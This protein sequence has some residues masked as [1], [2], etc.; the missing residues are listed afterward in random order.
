MKASELIKELQKQ[1][2]DA[3]VGDREVFWW[4]DKISNFEKVDSV[5]STCGSIDCI[6]L[7]GI[8]E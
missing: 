5:Y 6:A 2:D 7:N 4:N 3:S 8:E 1:I